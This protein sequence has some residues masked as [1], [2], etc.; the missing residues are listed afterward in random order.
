MIHGGDIYRNRVE[1]DFSVNVN[2][3][4]IPENVKAALM[5]A[6]SECMKYPDPEAERLRTVV[7][8]MLTVRE[9]A[10][11][12]GNGASELFMAV[13]HALMP[14]RI[15]IPV[16][17]FY[18]YEHAASACQGEIRYYQ[19]KREN[20]FTIDEGIFDLLDEETELLFLA[21]P[22]NPVGNLIPRRLLEKIL[23][24]CRDKNIYVVLD[25][26]FIE[27]GGQENSMLS[28]IEGYDNLLLIRAFTKIFAIPGVRFGYLVSS[29]SDLLLKLKRQ[30]P[31]WNLSIFSQMAGI[32]CAM[33]GSFIEHTREYVKGEREYLTTGLKNA[34]ITV[35]P[36]AANFIMLYT[37]T[38]LYE[39]LLKRRILIRDCSNFRGLSKGYYRIAV[40]SR[41]ENEKLLKRIGELL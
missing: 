40:K 3:L 9:E 19:M 13:I 37:E 27:F 26:C 28:Q 15:V 1:N 20:G 39:E 22:N 29:N 24:H 7:S 32:A 8:R 12:F 18:G 21:N 16:P 35:F 6:V 10:L 25:E 38:A 14:K 31:E 11:L 4:G 17:S 41:E 5:S 23:G 30:L 2:P 33:E 34:G 36:A